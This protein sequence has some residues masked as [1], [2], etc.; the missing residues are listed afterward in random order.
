M[1]AGLRRFFGR[2][3]PGVRA[4][5]ILKGQIG[6]GWYDVD[7][8]LELPRG[9]T[10]EGLL[11]EADRQGIALRAAIAAS[12]HLAH[13]LM[14]NGERAPVEENLAREVVDGDEVYLLAPMAG[15]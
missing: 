9:A 14:W 5:V 2:P 1:L 7:R 12:P 10:L 13:T 4:H 8:W 15:G 3:R 11:D 6:E